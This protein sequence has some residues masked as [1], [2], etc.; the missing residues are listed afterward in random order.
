MVGYCRLYLYERL[1]QN[2]VVG[3]MF[4]EIDFSV[5]DVKSIQLLANTI[6]IKVD[7]H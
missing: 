6:L 7:I 1:M 2:K 5:K 3:K 4:I